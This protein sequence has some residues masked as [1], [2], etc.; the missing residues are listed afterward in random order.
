MQF[1]LWSKYFTDDEELRGQHREI[2][3]RFEHLFLRR[4]ADIEKVQS[5]LQEKESELRSTKEEVER[6]RRDI[7]KLVTQVEALKALKLHTLGVGSGSRQ[8]PQRKK[9][10]QSSSSV[11]SS[12]SRTGYQ[13]TP[14]PRPQTA[15]SEIS[16][17]FLTE[18]N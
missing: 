4:C 17:V 12:I 2:L 9:R 7:N 16:S 10:P 15:L 5:E 8:I 18:T 13:R 14:S 3:D 6:K 11:K 1:R